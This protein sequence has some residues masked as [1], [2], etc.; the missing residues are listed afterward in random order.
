MTATAHI[1]QHRDLEAASHRPRPQRVIGLWQSRRRPQ[2]TERPGR[3]P[4]EVALTA[5]RRPGCSEPGHCVLPP[6]PPPP[7]WPREPYLFRRQDPGAKTFLLVSVWLE[8]L[9]GQAQLL[10]ERTSQLISRRSTVSLYQSRV[11]TSDSTFQSGQRAPHPVTSPRAPS[12]QLAGDSG[13]GQGRLTPARSC[14][15]PASAVPWS[16]AQTGKG[17]TR[18]RQRQGGREPRAPEQKGLRRR[19]TPG[20]PGRSSLQS[21][22]WS[23][24]CLLQTSETP[25]D[26]SQRQGAGRMPAVTRQR[27]GP[28]QD[29]A[30][31]DKQPMHEKREGA[32]GAKL[33]RRQACGAVARSRQSRA[34]RAARKGGRADVAAG[35]WKTAGTRDAGVE[36]PQLR[37]ESPVK[38]LLA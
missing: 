28:D 3:P 22:G 9:Q 13:A 20:P 27:T 16:L 34:R 33:S 26:P 6:P 29:T 38:A 24:S 12:P 17:Q 1:G 5:D 19:W 35:G 2:L 25:K 14:A 7:V 37:V 23:R 11:Q 18:Q 8:S 4:A 36:G 31:V 15:C 10:S 30:R 32:P 21:R